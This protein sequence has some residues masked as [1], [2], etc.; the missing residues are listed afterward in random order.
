[1]GD[2]LY[3]LAR[4]EVIIADAAGHTRTIT[5]LPNGGDGGGEAGHGD[6]IFLEWGGV[7]YYVHADGREDLLLDTQLAKKNTADIYYDR[8]AK[9]L[10]VPGFNAKTVTAYRLKFTGTTAI[11]NVLLLNAGMLA[12]LKAKTATQNSATL[13]YI[14]EIQQRADKLLD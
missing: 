13:Q 7:V 6:L 8:A 3:I 5:T 9:I 2:S 4:K 10:Y 1:S 12:D 14:V 11:P